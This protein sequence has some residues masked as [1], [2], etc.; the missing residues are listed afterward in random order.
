M[1]HKIEE[2]FNISANKILDAILYSADIIKRGLKGIIAEQI[3]YET[4]LAELPSPWLVVEK[5]AKAGDFVIQNSKT[6]K[7]IRIQIKM[8]RRAKGEPLLSD[9]IAK[10]RK[11]FN[12][13][14]VVEVQKTRSG[15]DSEGKPTRRYKDS[16]FDILAVSLYASSGDWTM[17]RFIET[18]DLLSKEGVLEIYQAVPKSENEIWS[19]DLIRFLK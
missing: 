16:D 17:F 19:N 1:K 10:L 7:I 3:F 8:Q 5:D 6:K 2:E 4:F 14:W 11:L 18:K 9:T 12:N 15:T 13:C